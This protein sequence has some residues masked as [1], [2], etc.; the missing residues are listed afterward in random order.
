MIAQLPAHAGVADLRPLFFDLT[1]NVNT[2]G[3]RRWGLF[4]WRAYSKDALPCNGC[5]R[6]CVRSSILNWQRRWIKSMP[7]H[8]P[9]R[10]FKPPTSYK[11]YNSADRGWIGGP[12]SRSSPPWWS[13]RVFSVR[14]VSVQSVYG[15]D[16]KKYRPER[17]ETDDLQTLDA[18]YFPFNR[19]LRACLGK[20]FALMEVS[21]IIVRIFLATA[22]LNLPEND[23]IE[24]V[25]T[26]KQDVAIVLSSAGGCRVAIER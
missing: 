18:D 19:G 17:W 8:L 16:A 9:T 24:P 21:Y 4:W 26:E 2:S 3:H 7:P 13:S 22:G 25:G 14:Q 15:E 11:D 20:D 1:L 5:Q 6:K 10:A 23:K 12:W